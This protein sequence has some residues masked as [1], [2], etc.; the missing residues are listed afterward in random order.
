MILKELLDILPDS[1]DISIEHDGCKTGS[2]V[3]GIKQFDKL[4][5]RK[6]I[7]AEPNFVKSVDIQSF[8]VRVE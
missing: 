1:L 2:L 5:N 3:I 4:V 8:N 6:V 7:S